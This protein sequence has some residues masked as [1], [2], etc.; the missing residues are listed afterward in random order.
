MNIAHVTKNVARSLVPETYSSWVRFKRKKLPKKAS[1][2]LENPIPS[3]FYNAPRK[4]FHTTH[5]YI[6]LDR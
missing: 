5:I 6:Q 2:I 3:L 4:I 1:A